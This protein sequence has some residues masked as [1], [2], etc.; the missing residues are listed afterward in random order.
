MVN[1][2]LCLCEEKGRKR[3]RQR[4]RRGNKTRREGEVEKRGRVVMQRMILKL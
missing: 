4:G 2:M 3:Q 1:G